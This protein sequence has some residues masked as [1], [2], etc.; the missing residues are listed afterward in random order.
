M[1]KGNALITGANGGIGRALCSAFR[2]AGWD[3]IS[4]DR[5]AATVASA[6]VYVPLDLVRLCRDAAYRKDSV[7][8]V[9]TILD[10]NGLRVLVNNAALQV[11]APVEGLSSEDWHATMDVNVIAPFLLTQAFLP[12]IEK[13]GGS[14]INIASVHA[15]LTK[16]GFSPYATSKSALVGLTRALAVELGARVRVNAISPAAISTPMLEAGFSGDSEGLT[17]LAAY[18]PSGCI[19]TPEDVAGAA[20]YLAEAQGK[21]LNGATI[22][23]DGGI[24]NRLHDPG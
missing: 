11:V 10:R 15:Q 20:L 6:D 16:P 3:V 18:H 13:A 21:F 5:E 23:L 14:V 17:R 2:D 19:G 24:G 7:A 4:S 22:S 8:F 12:E 1:K 9:R